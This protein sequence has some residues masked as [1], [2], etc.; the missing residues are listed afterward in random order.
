MKP[1][2]INAYGHIT[3]EGEGQCPLVEPQD[4]KK[5]RRPTVMVEWASILA[6]YLGV[7]GFSP[8]P[9]N[10]YPDHEFSWPSSLQA[11]ARILLQIRPRP[12]LYVSFPIYCSITMLSLDAMPAEI[13]TAYLNKSYINYMLFSSASQSSTVLDRNKSK[14]YLPGDF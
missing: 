7:S 14:L 11:N 8:G 1:R 2:N 3:G 13:L 10:G 9:Q 4:F 5:R 6:S 12:L